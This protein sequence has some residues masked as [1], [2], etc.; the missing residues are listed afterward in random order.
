LGH[1]NGDSPLGRFAPQYLS[2][3]SKFLNT[4]LLPMGS[5]IYLSSVSKRK[6]DGYTMLTLAS[7]D[8]GFS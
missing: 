5:S 8:P 3:T 7:N 6:V 1:L 2:N 4:Y